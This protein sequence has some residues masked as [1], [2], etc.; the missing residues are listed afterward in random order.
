MLF[1]GTYRLDDFLLFSDEVYW[2]LFEVHNIAYWPVIPLAASGSILLA[3]LLHSR[4]ERQLR[5]TVVLSATAWFFVSWAFFWESYATINWAAVYV[6]PIFALEGI[7]LLCLSARQRLWTL[8]PQTI[9]GTVG[10]ALLLYGLVFYPLQ[11]L[12]AGRPAAALQLFGLAPD[13]TALATLGLLFMVGSG[14]L[15][16][17]CL[18][19]PIVWCLLSATTLYALGSWEAWPLTAAAIVSLILFPCWFLRDRK[20][21]R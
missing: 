17:I 2:R 10:T 14:W 4:K 3:Y 6:L 1:E 21:R 16:Q 7:L 18:I 12:A 19:A 8:K 13:P 5:A 20:H 9:S 15:A 11:G